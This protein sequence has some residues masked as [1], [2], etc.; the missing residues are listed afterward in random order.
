M[1]VGDWSDFISQIHAESASVVHLA[2]VWDSMQKIK[3]IIETCITYSALKGVDGIQIN[4]VFHCIKVNL[5][6][7]PYTI[8]IIF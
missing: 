1:P 7:P 6:V 4:L 2:L 3:G 8:K 5:R